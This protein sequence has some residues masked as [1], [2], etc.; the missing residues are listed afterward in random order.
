M[1]KIIICLYPSASPV[2]SVLSITD[3]TQTKL[4][5]SLNSN[6]LKKNYKILNF[7]RNFRNLKISKLV[8]FVILVWK[9]Y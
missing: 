2:E 1:E 8:N 6:K 7:I 9:L 3:N 4:R 5:N